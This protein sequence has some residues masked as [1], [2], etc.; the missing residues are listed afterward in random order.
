MWAFFVLAR[1]RRGFRSLP[2]NEDDAFLLTRLF[3]VCF[4]LLTSQ[5]Q[6]NWE[7]KTYTPGHRGGQHGMMDADLERKVHSTGKS[8]H[9]PG[10]GAG[11]SMTSS[12]RLPRRR[13]G[14]EYYSRASLGCPWESKK[15]D[16]VFPRGR[17]GFGGCG[18]SGVSGCWLFKTVW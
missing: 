3:L 5:N 18:R 6:R 1:G 10:G 8:K 2:G 9:Q 4:L 16:S 12:L 15:K 7:G 17:A 14:W 13:L 11:P